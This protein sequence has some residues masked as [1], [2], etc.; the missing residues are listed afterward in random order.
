MAEIVLL[1]NVRLSFPNLVEPRAA[2]DNPNAQKKYSA[3]FIMDQDNPAFKQ[4]MAECSK[5]ALEKWGEHANNVMQLIQSDR[6]LRCFGRGDERIDKKTF[7][8]YKGYE[9]KVY[10]AANRIEPPQMIQGDGSAV[11]AG[12]TMAYQMLARKLYGGCRVNAAVRPWLQDNQ[13]GRGIRCDLIAV[14]FAGDDEA[15]GEGATDASTLF[16]AVACSAAP[17]AGLPSFFG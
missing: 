16:G 11:D 2:A 3:D 5:L 14:Q 17:A 10:I 7:A 1:S 12:N 15:F 6:R 13:H 4:F 9:G 8:P